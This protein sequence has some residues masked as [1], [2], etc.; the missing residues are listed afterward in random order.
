VEPKSAL[1]TWLEKLQ[2]ESWNLELLV[3]GFSIFLLV[4]A[5]REYWALIP[6]GKGH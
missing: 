4:Q 6:F 2:Q 3:S 1:H 5:K